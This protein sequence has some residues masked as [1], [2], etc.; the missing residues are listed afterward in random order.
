MLKMSTHNKLSQLYSDYI[1]GST[2][3]IHVHVHVCLQKVLQKVN[4]LVTNH[5]HSKPYSNLRLVQHIYSNKQAEVLLNMYGT[6][7][8]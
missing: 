8:K 4:R 5:F 1:F 2:S 6:S 7:K 3:Y